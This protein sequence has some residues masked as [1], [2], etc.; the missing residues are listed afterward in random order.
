MKMCLIDVCYQDPLSDFQQ[1]RDFS[2]SF[3]KTIIELTINIATQTISVSV[4]S[5]CHRNCLFASL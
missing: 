4:R 5:M 2:K 3:D 1:T